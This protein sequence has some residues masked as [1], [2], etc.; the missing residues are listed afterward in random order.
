VLAVGL[1]PA[2]LSSACARRVCVRCVIQVVTI[3]AVAPTTDP[4]AAAVAMTKFESISPSRLPPVADVTSIRTRGRSRRAVRPGIRHRPAREV[5]A[6]AGRGQ[7]FR[8]RDEG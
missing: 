4:N 6:L 5:P 3:D 1:A 8:P 7:E 2:D